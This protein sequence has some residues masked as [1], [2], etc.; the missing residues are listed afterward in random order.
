MICGR[1]AAS[2]RARPVRLARRFG[3]AAVGHDC[4]SDHEVDLFPLGAGRDRTEAVYGVLGVVDASVLE[5]QPGAQCLDDVAGTQADTVGEC[6]FGDLKGFFAGSAHPTRGRHPGHG[7][8]I[9]TEPCEREGPRFPDELFVERPV[10]ASHDRTRVNR[11]KTTSSKPFGRA[12]SMAISAA[13]PRPRRR[14]EC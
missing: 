13:S 7:P 10:N 4:V 14:P 9:R 6:R 11:A 5:E 2:S 8:D 12:I 1:R 3:I